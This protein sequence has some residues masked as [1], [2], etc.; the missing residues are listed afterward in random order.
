MICHETISILL[1]HITVGHSWWEE[2]I[3]TKI[4]TVIKKKR[5]KIINTYL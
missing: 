5:E 4:M 1:I 3:D 2:E